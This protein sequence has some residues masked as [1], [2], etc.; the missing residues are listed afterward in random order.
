MI[1]TTL[2]IDKK[3]F[4]KVIERIEALPDD[5]QAAARLTI[6][7]LEG[8]KRKL[9]QEAPP[10]KR[11]IEWTS[12]KQRR[13]YFATNG[14]GSGIPYRRTGKLNRA[15]VTSATPTGNGAVIVLSNEAPIAKYVYGMFGAPKPQQGFH[16]N[17]GWQTIS[18]QQ[19]EVMNEILYYFKTELLKVLSS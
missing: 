9:A 2:T 3:T 15:W 4:N 18:K 19:Y 13:A 14:F 7:E 12:E 16:R 17:T 8:V 6:P 5:I 11:P 10:V 1:S